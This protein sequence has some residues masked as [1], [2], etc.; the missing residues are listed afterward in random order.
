LPRDVEDPAIAAVT[1]PSVRDV[2]RSFLGTLRGE[3]LAILRPG[4]LPHPSQL[5]SPGHHPTFRASYPRAVDRLS[6][7]GY[8]GAKTVRNGVGG[9]CRSPPSPH[10]LRRSD[11]DHAECGGVSITD[12]VFRLSR[13]RSWLGWEN[14]VFGHIY[15]TDQLTGLYFGTLMEGMGAHSY[16]FFGVWTILVTQ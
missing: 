14:T 13:K 4:V 5:P 12:T 9:R 3:G 10:A 11:S 1:C 7:G 2:D 8:G 6:G 15:L 16:N